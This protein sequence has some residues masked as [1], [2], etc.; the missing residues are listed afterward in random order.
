ME[1][2][3]LP[4]GTSHYITA[5][6]EAPPSAWFKQTQTFLSFPRSRGYTAENLRGGDSLSEEDRNDPAGFFKHSDGNL[7]SVEQ[8]FQ[9]WLFFGLAIDVLDL[10]NVSVSTEDFL[11]PAAVGTARIVDTSKLPGFLVRWERNIRRDDN[12]SDLFHELNVRFTKAA[13]V[14]DRFCRLPSPSS[15]DERA[16]YPLSTTK[17]RP[18]PVRDAIAT[19]CI[20]LVA[21]LRQAAIRA[22]GVEASVDGMDVWPVHARSPILKRRLE[23]KFCVADVASIQ[24]QL[25]VDGLYFLAGSGSS[26]GGLDAEELDHHA[27]CERAHCLYEYDG[28]MYVT[29]HT[30]DQYHVEGHCPET[31]KYGA[32]LGPERGQKDWS[33]ALRKILDKDDV[34]PIALWNKGR[35]EV[36]S[37]EYH[38]EGTRKPDY[39]AI[40]HVW[41]QGK[42]NP[43]GNA[44]P[45]CQMD[46]IQ[47]LVEGV[48]WEGRKE[49][50]ANPNYSNGVGFW[51]D[52][53]CLPPSATDKRRNTKAIASMRHVYANAKA[54]LIL[55][56]WIEQI[57]YDASTP[58]EVM[59][60]IYTSNWH[61]RLWTHQEGFL[62]QA[63]WFQFADRAVEVQEISARL[64]EHR[65]ALQRK[66]M[67]PGWPFAAHARLTNVYSWLPARFKNTSP[68]DKWT[69]YP[70]LAMSMSERKTSRL[71]DETICLAT[72]INIPLGPFQEIES[73]PDE[74]AGP[75]R[76]ERFVDEI[77]R[78]N[79]AIIFNN[80][81]RL[82]KSGYRWAPR[83]LLNLR[84]ADLAPSDPD[85]SSTPDAAFEVTWAERGLTVNFPGFLIRFEDGRPSFSAADRGCAIRCEDVADSRMHVQGSWF[86][87]QLPPND[88]EWKMG[89]QYAVILS[90]VPDPRNKG[91]RVPAVVASVGLS[92]QGKRFL[93][94][95]ES[96]ATVWVQET[97]PDWVDRFEQPLLP[98]GTEWVVT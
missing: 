64:D 30:G 73:K 10:G 49:V 24:K 63:L 50:P 26:V 32:Q 31:L 89:K 67:Y 78:F 80:Y 95:H 20:A 86:V 7:A 22:C 43:K 87:V 60:R 57:R 97:A 34:V 55:D 51:M 19:T 91:Q 47:R 52:T 21:T 38:C 23:R 77:G 14:L 1:H 39:V 88:V 96:I 90:W 46:R 53:L 98:S 68:E 4:T 69:T 82:E 44:L 16:L 79:S 65:A 17:P 66:G 72:I 75:R 2:L 40:S 56:D 28:D 9:T 5:P 62:S 6:Y 54:V 12:R 93:V 84:T 76:M 36:W 29:R 48:T 42:G 35:K 41:A 94:A 83:S 37:V 8:F 33:D 11:K 81:A 58:L 59:A 70:L 25:P 61:K 45:Q 13:E 3:P 74:V 15:S 27:S 18:W 85:A 92:I 71:A